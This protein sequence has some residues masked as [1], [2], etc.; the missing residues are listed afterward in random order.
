[1]DLQV[2]FC[3]KSN[4]V[5]YFIFSFLIFILFLPLARLQAQDKFYNYYDRGS[6]Y[7]EKGDWLRALEE[8][9]SAASLEYED[10]KNKRTYGTHFIEYFPHR[11]MGVAYFQL[12]ECDNARRELEL[13][14]AYIKSNRAVDFLSRCGSTSGFA[15]V[16]VDK[17]KELQK[18]KELERQAQIQKQLEEQNEKLRR[19]QERQEQERKRMEQLKNEEEKKKEIKRQAETQK[20]LDE[21]R[22]RIKGEQEKLEK[23]KRLMEASKAAVSSSATLAGLLYD[24]SK[25]PQ[26]GSHLSVAVLPFQS[27]GEGTGL[28]AEISEKLTTQMVNLRRF[29]VLEREQMDKVMQEQNFSLSD[30]V[31][32]STVKKVGKILDADVLVVGSVNVVSGFAKVSAR[33][34]DVET[35]ETIVAKEKETQS[36]DLQSIE[37]KVEELAVAIYNEIPVLEGLIINP[38]SDESIY[39][40]IGS[41]RGMRKGTKCVA[42]REGDEIIHPIT[43][44]SLGRKVT[45][46]GEI[47][48]TQVQEQFSIGK[49]VKSE[50]KLKTGDKI[51][52]K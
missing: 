30:N 18:Q 9:K 10:K 35:S 41:N 52:I 15:G 49:V 25:F 31:D 45:P 16:V 5:P 21:E 40:D 42:Y 3:K 13:S 11:E 28:G 24:I 48:I 34:I 38:E 33:L 37:K 32:P 26:V 29:K 27:K 51:L 17:E 1:M 50:G 6:K 36:T 2:A 20:K 7:L 23:A 44:Q 4:H 22:A 12:G 39:I 47:V 46:L 14:L 19:D 8:F 43:K